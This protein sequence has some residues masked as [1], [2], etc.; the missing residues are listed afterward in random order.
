LKTYVGIKE[1]AK[2][3]ILELGTEPTKENLPQ[4]DIVYGPFKSREDAQGYVIATGDL[5]CG[6]G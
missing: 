2:P 1:N 3:V 5:A 6:D 4:Y